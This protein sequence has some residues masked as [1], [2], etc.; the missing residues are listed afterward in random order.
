MSGT[1]DGQFE[2]MVKQF[3]QECRHYATTGQVSSG[4]N[5]IAA[6]SPQY[7]GA[8]KRALESNDDKGARELI[9][10]VLGKLL[11]KGEV[12]YKVKI[13]KFSIKD[14]KIDERALG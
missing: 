6:I 11:E 9:R 5:I 14:I 2:K 4:L 7:S 1:T 8:I 10:T 13:K 12:K 3:Y